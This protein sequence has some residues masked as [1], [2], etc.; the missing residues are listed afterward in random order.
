MAEPAVV[1]V[2]QDRER[3][4]RGRPVLLESL[5]RPP[6]GSDFPLSDGCSTYFC[7]SIGVDHGL[8]S[9]E[10]GDLTHMGPDGDGA[11]PYG[12]NTVRKERF[13]LEGISLAVHIGRP[14]GARLNPGEKIA[15]HSQTRREWATPHRVVMRCLTLK[16]DE[17]ERT[18]RVDPESSLLV[19]FSV[20]RFT[21][22]VSIKS[23]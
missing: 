20:H 22:M 17:M 16:G 6:C 9:D 8:T 18:V 19:A 5:A 12:G 15:N 23:A 14:A 13:A 7:L 3:K 1:A 21:D 4:L 10:I 11:Y 2:T